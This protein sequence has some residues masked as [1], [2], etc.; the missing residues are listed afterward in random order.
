MAGSAIAPGASKETHP[1]KIRE[2]EPNDCHPPP[3]WGWGR[4]TRRRTD[5]QL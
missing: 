1:P 3:G 5:G 4:A 2:G